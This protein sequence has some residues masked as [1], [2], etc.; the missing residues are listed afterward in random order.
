MFLGGP[1]QTG[2]HRRQDTIILP[3]PRLP[4]RRVL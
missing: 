3:A 2:L 1:E 4:V